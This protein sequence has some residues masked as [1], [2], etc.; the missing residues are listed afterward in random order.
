LPK[1][2]LAV[3][4]LALGLLA[5]GLA[6]ASGL[7]QRPRLELIGAYTIPTEEW[8]FEA[9]PVGGLSGLAYDRT[10]DVYYAV[11]DDRGET[12]PAGRFYTL[13]VALAERGIEAIQVLAT[14][15]LDSDLA[16]TGVQP[17]PEKGIDAE[18]VV[19]TPKGRSSSP[20]SETRRTALGSGSSP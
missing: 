8:T 7:G 6:L 14:T 3:V 17:Y 4:L 1:P 16:T 18:E 10:K 19:L 20:P 12:G 11:S 13:R 9:V 15:L 5:L 2:I